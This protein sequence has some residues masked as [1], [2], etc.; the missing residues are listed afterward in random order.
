MHKNVYIHR[1][2]YDQTLAPKRE[3]DVLRARFARRIPPLEAGHP[4][5]SIARTATH[6]RAH[7]NATMR[8]HAPQ[9]QTLITKAATID[10]HTLHRAPPEAPNTIAMRRA[11]IRRIS[12][13]RSEHNAMGT[14]SSR[15]HPKGGGGS[16][17]QN[18]P[19]TR[20]AAA[21][22]ISTQQR[23][24]SQKPRHQLRSK[25]KIILNLS[26]LRAH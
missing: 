20:P 11:S 1:D 10:P 26:C 6:D 24:A 19:N 9:P 7:S 13:E 12:D 18:R 14:L 5:T 25:P 16:S 3:I 23:S 15:Q 2:F 17:V 4:H 21:A 8:K 22:A